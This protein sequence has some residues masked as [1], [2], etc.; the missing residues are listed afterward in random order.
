MDTVN[1]QLMRQ[2]VEGD[3]SR[4]DIREMLKMNPKDK[5]R[6]FTYLEVLQEKVDWDDQILLRISDNLYIVKKPTG[7]RITKCHCGHDFDDYRINWKTGCNVRVRKTAESI[8]EVYYPSP[9]CPEPDWTQIR[10]FYCPSC[11]RQLGVEAAP[12]GYP[13][14]FE[15]LPDIDRLYRE[16]LDRPLDDESPDWYQDKTLEKTSQ[17]GQAIP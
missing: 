12:P 5:N 17:W 8:G 3:I 11:F 15:V 1:K 16:F 6:F 7:E 4:E 13:F 14:V 2:I 9:A 10:E